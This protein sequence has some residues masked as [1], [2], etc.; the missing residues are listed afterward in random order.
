MV[1]ALSDMRPTGAG[2]A[3][4]GSCGYGGESESGGGDG[5][6]GAGEGGGA[7]VGVTFIRSKATGHT[8]STDPSTGRSY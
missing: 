1:P 3:S 5:G 4:S 6:G 2:A 8:T 7:D